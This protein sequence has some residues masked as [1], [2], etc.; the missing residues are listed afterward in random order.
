MG[1]RVG[2]VVYRLLSRVVRQ[3]FEHSVAAVVRFPNDTLIEKIVIETKCWH[4]Y[5]TAIQKLQQRQKC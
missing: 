1:K 4:G 5:V 3:T 2:L